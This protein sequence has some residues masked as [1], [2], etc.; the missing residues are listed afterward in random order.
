MITLKE[1]V[2]YMSDNG[3]LLKQKE[4][5]LLTSKFNKEMLGL[6]IGVTVVKR[7]DIVVKELTDPPKPI[8]WISEYQ[9]FIIE[10]KVPRY[11]T[12]NKGEPYET[13]RATKPGRDA[14][15]KAMEKVS[16][17]D[18][19][20]AVQAYYAAGRGRYRVK[21]ET[22]FVDEHWLSI[23]QDNSDTRSHD[24]NTITIPNL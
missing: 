14:F 6:D 17:A 3:Y 13:S 9:N 24:G 5:Y 20:K 19:I 16:K 2:Q 7:E 22:F 21:I 23:I 1:A 12:N 11:S 10:A 8:D 15:K 18:L 4:R